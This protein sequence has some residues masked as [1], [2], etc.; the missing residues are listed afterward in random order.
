MCRFYIPPEHGDSH[1]FSASVAECTTIL[2]KV[3]TDP[4]YSG[5]IEESPNV[6]YMMLPDMITGACGANY[7]PVYRLWNQ[8]ADSNHRYTTDPGIKAAMMAKGFVAEGY[9]PDMRR[10]AHARRRAA[11]SMR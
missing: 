1:F 4:N 9:G 7:V 11:G 6:F 10:N 3:G 5:Y 8:R 2:G